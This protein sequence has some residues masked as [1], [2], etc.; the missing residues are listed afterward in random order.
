MLRL[1]KVDYD[2]LLKVQI[3]I[4]NKA[5][6]LCKVNGILTYITCSIFEEENE[7]Q[8]LNFLKM[9]KKIEKRNIKNIFLNS[10]LNVFKQEKS[11]LTLLP[12][13]L[14]TDGYFI[15]SIKKIA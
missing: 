10:P 14:N 5:S 7:M 11:F 8:I 6:L 2:N 4:L 1:K 3:E 9:N 12:T 15:S 13:S